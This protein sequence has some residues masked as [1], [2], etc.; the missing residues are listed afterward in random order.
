[1]LARAGVKA[2]FVGAGAAGA[3]TGTAAA[4]TGLG[5]SGSNSIAVRTRA[6]RPASTSISSTWPR[7]NSGLSAFSVYTP[8]SRPVNRKAPFFAVVERHSAP[9]AWLRSTTV[10]PSSGFECRS[11]SLPLSAP[12]DPS[13]TTRISGDCAKPT[14]AMLT[15][16]TAT[17]SAFIH[18]RS[19]PAIET[20]ARGRPRKT[21]QHT[22]APAR[23]HGKSGW[24]RI[25]QLE[26][27]CL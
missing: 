22:C 8:G 7:P 24:S 2:T 15:R 14:A 11:V 13:S 12:V 3:G 21:P 17:A 5:E 1:M 16:S 9:V 25:L 18:P 27:S 10:T 23:S 4:R 20:P 26:V 19:N 6:S